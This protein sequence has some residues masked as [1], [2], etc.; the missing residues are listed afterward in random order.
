MCNEKVMKMLN[1]AMAKQMQ[2]DIDS[3]KFDDVPNDKNILQDAVHRLKGGQK[4]TGLQ[5]SVRMTHY[6]D[7]G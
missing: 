6:W 3:G 1:L 5:K 7:A 4:M 2:N